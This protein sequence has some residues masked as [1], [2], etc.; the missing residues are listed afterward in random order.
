MF[1][2]AR[3]KVGVHCD[4][5]KWWY[6]F[7]KRSAGWLRETYKHSLSH[8]LTTFLSFLFVFPACTQPEKACATVWGW[9]VWKCISKSPCGWCTKKRCVCVVKLWPSPDW[10]VGP[11]A[12]LCQSQT[13]NLWGLFCHRVS[14]TTEPLT[15]KLWLF[16][17]CLWN[18]KA[19][20]PFICSHHICEPWTSSVSVHCITIRPLFKAPFRHKM[21]S[22]VW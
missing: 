17:L 22:S 10:K 18:Y 2:T 1:P 20:A 11:W 8:C 7:C 16:S 13:S 9:G 12:T 15:D 4:M 21:F 3:D 5:M 6:L 19:T 14:F